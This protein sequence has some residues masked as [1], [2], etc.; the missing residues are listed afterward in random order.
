MFSLSSQLHFHFKKHIELEQINSGK[1]PNKFYGKN[2]KLSTSWKA[3]PHFFNN[4]MLLQTIHPW[5]KSTT[6]VFGSLLFI[7]NYRFSSSSLTHHTLC[8]NPFCHGTIL[9]LLGKTGSSTS[10]Q[11]GLLREEIWNLDTQPPHAALRINGS[12]TKNLQGNWKQMLSSCWMTKYNGSQIQGI[13][14]WTIQQRPLHCPK[15]KGE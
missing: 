1:K 6:K 2:L 13:N 5:E 12:K 8:G 9:L 4:T 3:H 14:F 15:A 11:K 7:N 10:R